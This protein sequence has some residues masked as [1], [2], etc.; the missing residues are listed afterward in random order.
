MDLSKA[1]EGGS[2]GNSFSFPVVT[3]CIPCIGSLRY[4]IVPTFSHAQGCCPRCQPYHSVPVTTLNIQN[5]LIGLQETES[6]R[7]V[8][9]LAL[10]A[11][12]STAN[13]V[14]VEWRFGSNY[15]PQHYGNW[16]FKDG[17]WSFGNDKRIECEACGYSM[18]MLIDRLGDKF[19]KA[20]VQNEMKM[21]CSKE[22][23]QWVFE[24]GCKHITTKNGPQ[25]VNAIMRLTEPEDICKQLNYCAPDFYDAAA[26][27]GMGPIGGRALGANGG[28]WAHSGHAISQF[29]YGAGL[30]GQYGVYPAPGTRPLSAHSPYSPYNFGGYDPYGY[31]LP[32]PGVPSSTPVPAG[33]AKAAEKKEEKK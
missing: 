14:G 4:T 17:T 26:M 29:G 8:V 13:A 15:V 30:Q 24:S 33:E 9:L 32:H 27:G 25:I 23:I 19:T 16:A 10:I 18:Y 5:N 12:L 11:T 22:K 21:V 2:G 28:G 7:V 6:M 20:T 31:P 3:R 1:K